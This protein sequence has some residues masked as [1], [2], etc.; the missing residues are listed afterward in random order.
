MVQNGIPA[1]A[2]KKMGHVEEWLSYEIGIT[3]GQESQKTQSI[4]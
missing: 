1:L 3:C 4:L 2:A